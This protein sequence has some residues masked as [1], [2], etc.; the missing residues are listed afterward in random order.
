MEKVL[1]KPVDQAV[2]FL[3]KSCPETPSAAVVLGSGVKVL[4]QLD[5]EISFPYQDVFGMSP[6][7]AGHAGSLSFGYLGKAPVVVLRGRFHAY[8]GHDWD[9]VTLVTRVMIEWGVPRLYLTNAAG[10]LNR[11]FQV[12]DLMVLTGYRDH[13]NPK[14]RE[15]GLLPALMAD[16]T[17]CENEASKQLISIGEKLAGADKMFRPLQKGVYAGLLGPAYET[18]AE[19]EMLRRLNVDAV[20]MSTIP[21]LQTAQGTKTTACAV[22]VVT[23]VWTDEPIGGHEEVLEAAKEASERLDKLFRAV[24][25]G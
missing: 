7:V 9:V 23:N 15:T 14:W 22:S 10:G 1:A 16:S 8:E 3:R 19:V 12:G 24:I 18:M 13:L 25:A 6:G 21:E 4:E 20:G 17:A 11:S 5:G 2:D